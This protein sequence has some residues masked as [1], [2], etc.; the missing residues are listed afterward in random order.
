MKKK[1]VFITMAVF[2]FCL[3]P[4]CPDGSSPSKPVDKSEI[5]SVWLVGQITDW[6]T[7]PKKPI[8]LTDEGGRIFTW[9]GT[10]PAATYLKFSGNS[11]MPDDY[12]SG[13]W[14][15][16]R[17]INISVE[18]K[19]LGEPE[20]SGFDIFTS[21]GDTN[22]VIGYAGTYS[23]FVDLENMEV[24]FT[25]DEGEEVGDELSVWLVGASLG[26]D[27]NK[28]QMDP[29]S[30]ETNV[31]TWT[32]NLKAAAPEGIS[33]SHN[34]NGPPDWNNPVLK[35]W[36]AAS[37]SGI[38]VANKTGGQSF[39]LV[40]SNTQAP[41]FGIAVP[42]EYTITL[43]AENMTVVFSLY[44]PAEEDDDFDVWLI[45]SSIGW[46]IPPVADQK[47]EKEGDGVFSWTGNLIV[48][49]ADGEGVSFVSSKLGDPGWWTGIWFT[50]PE[51]DLGDRTVL[52]I[53]EEQEFDVRG[54]PGQDYLWNIIA[55][56]SYTI[57]LDTG[58]MKI[59]FIKND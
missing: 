25:R 30:G 39:D 58:E 51:E 44:E 55:E 32:G 56:G 8:Q 9:T 10:I 53:S 42:G 35:K 18:C 21:S 29:V 59:L 26:W 5:D 41:M 49:N 12:E 48:A 54:F 33:F 31:F 34:K 47:M 52:D 24:T 57:T 38:I 3:L 16:P 46:T 15:R 2:I 19:V 11:E 20:T 37:R 22:W 45:G 36:F 43:D 40:E 17:P 13:I 50:S 1:F 23:I 7:G 14:L 27:L 28:Y 6:L 4:G